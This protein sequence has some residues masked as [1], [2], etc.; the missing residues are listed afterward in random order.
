MSEICYEISRALP[1]VAE[2]DVLVAGGGPGGLGAAVMAARAGAKTVLVERYGY[3]GGM[4]S[5][6]EV[7]PF[8]PNHVN[9]RTLDT[10]VYAE[11]AERIHSYLPPN[12]QENIPFD[13][14]IP[15]GK[16]RMLSKDAAMLAAEDLCVEAGVRILY[17]HWVADAIVAQRLIKAVVLLSK[18]GFTAANAACYVDCTGDGDL[19]VLAG[20]EY[21]Q[22]GPSGHSQ[23]MTLCFKLSHVNRDRM[24]SQVELDRLFNAAKERGEILTPRHNVLHFQH[25]DDDVV[26]FNTTR[27]CHKSGTN[28]VELS[29]AERDARRQMREYLRFFRTYVSGFEQCRIH[30]LG[31]HIGVRETR[32]IK[33]INFIRREVFSNAMKFEDGICRCCYGIDIHNPD[34]SGTEHEYIPEGD[35]FE[36]PYGCVVAKDVDNLTIG[37]RPISVD[38]A[39]HS[40]MRVMPPACTVGQAAGMGAALSAQRGCK[41]ADLEGVE[42]RA[43]LC[44]QG[45]S[46]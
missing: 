40:S 3:L 46:L 7:H 16:E 25:H 43:L 23:P 39:I 41:P 2:A 6:G 44:K 32:R 36:I 13:K 5:S 33:G 11:W 14:T 30:S 27:V 12:A 18:S 9:G 21:E 20:C 35:Y 37:G 22:G 19:A 42:V 8:M 29:D 15:S 1:I 34:G 45:A 24:P 28:G 10:P 17:H 4:A 31:H 26:H 38:H